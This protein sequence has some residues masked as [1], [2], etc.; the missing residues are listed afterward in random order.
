M[1]GQCSE[2]QKLCLLSEAA[3]AAGLFPDCYSQLGSIEL[4][5]YPSPK[6]CPQI[7]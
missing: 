6:F 2:Q 1:G 5:F 3:S 7:L 4:V